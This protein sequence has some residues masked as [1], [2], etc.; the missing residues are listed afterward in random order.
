MR[1][2]V[3]AVSNFEL[4]DVGE[5]RF[6]LSG[7]MSFITAERILRASENAFAGQ[8]NLEIDLSGVKDTDSA[9]L[10]LLLEWVSLANQ[11]GSDIRFKAIPEKVHAIAQTADVEDLLNH[12]SSSSSKK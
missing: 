12:S 1:A 8:S 3:R 4:V 7:D 10:A 2:L 11:T 5:G 6:E 9:G